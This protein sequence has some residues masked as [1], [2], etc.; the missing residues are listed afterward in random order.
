[1]IFDEGPAYVVMCYNLHGG[2]SSP[3]GKANP[4]FILELIEK[5][6]K[7]PG[8]KDFAVATGGFNWAKNGRTTAV[9]ETEANLI[10]KEYKSQVKRDDE[11]KC[12]FFKYKDKDS[13]E[14][15]VWYA[16]KITLKS[17]MSVIIEK[18]YDTSIWRLGGK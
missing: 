18:G 4:K 13:I 12:L 14:H 8:K 9:S 2:F 3:G 1:L 5:A 6:R 16:D 10:L 15:E 17:W 11:S 7:I